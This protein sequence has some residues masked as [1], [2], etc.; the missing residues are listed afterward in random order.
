MPKR[1][2]HLEIYFHGYSD[3][4]GNICVH[5]DTGIDVKV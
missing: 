3:I 2:N 4:C 1:K 5:E